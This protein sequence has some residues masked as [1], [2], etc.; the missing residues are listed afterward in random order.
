MGFDKQENITKNENVLAGIVGAFLFSL[1]GGV[2][3]FLLHLTGVFASISGFVGV[4]LAILGYKLFA[5]KE[6]IKG[7][8]IASVIAFAV[9]VLA[10]YLCVG[11]D[12]YD[13][14]QYYYN[15]GEID[16][17]LS[18]ADSLRS[19]P[20][21]LSDPEIG[22]SCYRDLIIGLVFALIGSVGT[23][24]RSIRNVK[25]K[26]APT[27]TEAVVDETENVPEETPEDTK[28]IRSAQT[29]EKVR[30]YLNETAFGHNV[31]FRKVGKKKDELV[32]DGQVFAVHVLDAV[33][34]P[35]EMHAF[36]DGHRFEAGCA[37]GYGNY[38]SVDDTVIAKKFR[39]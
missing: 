6:S 10:W 14:Y 32:I 38:I 39:W 26:N 31:I 1:G 8:I 27:V 11:K 28:P 19:V 37:A 2:V 33:Q 5:K 3:W 17:T 12:I 9:L 13:A 23:I 20:S 24:I 29:D 36:L 25:A 4:F 35:Y 34:F 22:P 7:I 15:S 21:F 30:E 16:Y 18:Y